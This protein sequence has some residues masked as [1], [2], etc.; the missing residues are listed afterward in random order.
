MK[1]VFISYAREDGDVADI[2]R[3]HLEDAGFPTWQDVDLYGGQD[4]RAEIDLAIRDARAV[5]VMMSPEASR[6]AYVGYE[7]A[8]ALG[9]GVNVIPLLLKTKPDELHP[10]IRGRQCLDFS[11]R[12]ARPWD[13][14]IRAIEGAAPAVRS[15]T[16]RIP[17]DA[18]PAVEMAAR[19]L[20]SL[21]TRDRE[22]ALETL[23]K[24]KHPSVV[25]VLADAV[26]HPIQDVR[27]GAAILLARYGDKRALRGLLEGVRAHP[28]YKIHAGELSG[29]GRQVIEELVAALQDDNLVVRRVAADA[30]GFI[31]DAAAIPALKETLGSEDSGLL[32]SAVGALGNMRD[33][34]LLPVFEQ[35][36]RDRR[37]CSTAL[38]A[39]AKLPGYAGE[40]ILTEALGHEDSSVRFEAVRL[41]EDAASPGALPALIAALRDRSGQV[42]RVAVGAIG[43][44]G[45]A[46][47]VS[48]LLEA[49][50]DEENLV[51]SQAGP[52]LVKIGGPLVA[53]GLTTV[54][55]DPQRLNRASAAALLGELGDMSAIPALIEVLEDEELRAASASALG[56]LAR[57]GMPVV[58]SA[59][60]ELLT[61]HDKNVRYRAVDAV[62]MIQDPAS[63]VLLDASLRDP[64][65]EVSRGAADGLRRIGTPEAL[66]R[67]KAW[68][69]ANQQG[70]PDEDMDWKAK[71][72][73][74]RQSLTASLQPPAGAG[75]PPRNP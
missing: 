40:R 61:D 38:L 16:V 63:I 7:W 9:A 3:R 21:E 45:G 42:R 60:A 24:M 75:V 26:N 56:K 1:R 35:A 32:C 44:L 17:T 29:L 62:G 15:A 69:R 8:L 41:L 34:A 10:A 14:L 25:E 50:E 23:G 43:N 19:A 54:L 66:A 73:A 59:L 57:P 67:L 33:P 2:V 39:A 6:S 36:L 12:Q 55:R 30:L 47:A 74:A 27:V 28:A 70:Q 22:A 53:S 31:G 5:V 64:E 68:H 71:M 49:L 11:N 20:D 4:W 37:T 51:S 52:A 13:L 65:Q 58:L 46:T 72:E 18:P 48:A